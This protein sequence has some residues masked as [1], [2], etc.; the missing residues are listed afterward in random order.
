MNTLEDVSC[1]RNCEKSWE[2]DFGL[3]QFYVAE[4]LHRSQFYLDELSPNIGIE[5]DKLNLDAIKRALGILVSDLCCGGAGAL[6]IRA[7][8]NAVSDVSD[9]QREAFLQMI[10]ILER[11]S[12]HWYPNCVR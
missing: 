10:E 6:Q 2:A 5:L 4:N 9:L 7:S 8:I 11:D 12:D 1:N 3:W